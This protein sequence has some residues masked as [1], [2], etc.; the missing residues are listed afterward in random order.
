MKLNYH[1]QTK[2]LKLKKFELIYPNKAF[3]K[4]KK[5]KIKAIQILGILN[6]L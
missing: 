1:I 5:I 4:M 2:N 3:Q 6:F